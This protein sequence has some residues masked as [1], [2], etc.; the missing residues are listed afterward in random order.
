ML[1]PFMLLSPQAWLRRLESVYQGQSH[2][3]GIKAPMLAWFNLLVVAFIPLNIGKLLW[4]EPPHLG[5]RLILNT[6]MFASALLSL[7]H[8]FRGRIAAA[9][10]TIALGLTVPM[11][12]ALLVPT[13]ARQPLATGIQL[14]GFDLVFLLLTAVFATRRVSLVVIGVILAG[15]FGFHFRHFSGDSP[16]GTVAFAADTLVRDGFFALGFVCALAVTLVHLIESA[17]RRSEQALRETRALNENLGRLVAARTRDLEAATAQA[18]AASQ[19]KS[20]FLANM[21]HEIRT[22]LNGIIASA[23]LL[24]RRRDLPPEAGESVR[25]I[26][27]SG[28]LLLKLLSDILDFSKIE[29]GQ[30]RLEHHAFQ[31]ADVV[32]DTIG[33]VASRAEFARLRLTCS[34]ARELPAVVTGDSYRLRQVLL[35]LLGNAVKFTPAGGRV[36]VQVTPASPASDPQLVRF[37]VRDTGIGID[38]ATRARIF[39]RF[40]QADASTTRRYGGTGLGLSISARLVDLMGGRLELDSTPGQGSTFAFVIPLTPGQPGAGPAAAAGPLPQLRLRVLVA[41]DNDTNR[42]IITRQLQQ[43]GCE[44]ELTHDGEALLARLS[45]EPRPDMVLMD[46]HMPNLDGWEATRR[47]RAW[48][49]ETPGPRQAAASLPILALTAATMPGEQARCREAGMDG[50]VAKP[51]RLAEL[52]S[53]L[54]PYARPDSPATV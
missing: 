11:H 43:L 13:E 45:T 40:T 19:A 14:F 32:N 18:N 24:Q 12:L 21:S 52:A 44:A 3:T 46:C 53:A 7:R 39:E 2:F 30:L 15:H 54:R 22:P 36:D 35:N 6:V 26:S 16:A 4:V 20:E 49:A 28:D 27:Q 33:L 29:A 9:G 38:A 37:A 1:R 51:V 17:H 34:L 47:I 5:I 10:N 41:E 31:L 48:A 23:D 25:L 8:L 50:F 42:R